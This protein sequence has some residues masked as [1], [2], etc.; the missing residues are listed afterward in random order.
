[1]LT[2]VEGLLDRDRAVTLVRVLPALE[3]RWTFR[4]EED[5]ATCRLF[6]LLAPDLRLFLDAFFAKMG[7]TNSIRAKTS[8]TKAILTLSR[9][10]SVD[11]ILLLSQATIADRQVELSAFDLAV[12][13]KTRHSTGFHIC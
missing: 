5:L 12:S 4:A 2:L 13:N 3:G 9:Y 6:W 7:S 11:I 10:F 8:V 1:V